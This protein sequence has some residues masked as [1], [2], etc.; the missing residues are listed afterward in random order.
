MTPLSQFIEE[1]I[2]TIYEELVIVCNKYNASKHKVDL[3][4]PDFTDWLRAHDKRLLEKVSK[5]I[6]VYKNYYN[7]TNDAFNQGRHEAADAIR[8]HLTEAIKE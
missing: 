3:W 1:E 8:S 5:E 4:F 7:P 2:K 6:E